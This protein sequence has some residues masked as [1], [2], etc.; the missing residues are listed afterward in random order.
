MAEPGASP[1]VDAARCVA[2]LWRPMAAWSLLVWAAGLLLLSPLSAFVLGNLLGSD[3]VISNEEVVSWLITPRGLVFLLLA[4]ASALTLSVAQFGGM[5]RLITTD[6]A[7]TATI[8]RA[9][10]ALTTG[11][12]AVF[13]FCLATVAAAVVLLA[14]LLLWVAFLYARFLREHDINYYLSAKPPVFYQA[15]L[16]AAPVAVIW[17]IG[18]IWVVVRI[19]PA[20]PA[21]FDGHRARRMAG[22]EER[23]DSGLLDR[24]VER[25]E[26]AVIRKE[27]LDVR[28]ELEAAH[29]VVADEAA[30]LVHRVRPVRVDGRERD[31]HVRVRSGDLGDLLVPHRGATRDGLGVDGEDDRGHVARAVVRRDVL[32]GRRA[33]SAEILLRRRPPLGTEAVLARPADLGVRVEVDRA[34]RGEVDG[35]RSSARPSLITALPSPSSASKPNPPPTRQMRVVTVS[36]G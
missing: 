33:A 7:R 16:L 29:A 19:L 23:R 20:L 21:F 26:R 35:H 6:R 10:M 31:Q 36:P 32:D 34:D 28:V 25:V 14:P 5:F 11:L 12:P 30:H 24:L 4:L 27:R 9:A 18:A 15:L 8:S 2:A 1:L 22:V 17:A 13:R 3:G